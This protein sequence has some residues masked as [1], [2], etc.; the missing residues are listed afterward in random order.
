MQ[1]P[2]VTPPRRRRTALTTLFVLCAAGALAVVTALLILLISHSAPARPVLRLTEEVGDYV[3][4]FPRHGGY[5]GPTADQRDALADGVAKVL[6]GRLDS[7]RERL[8][9][10]DYTVRT[11]RL[12]GTDRTVAEVTEKHRTERG[13]GRVYVDLDHRVRW[14]VQVPHPR[15]D[16]DT[17]LI[18][19]GLF[20]R[21]PGGILVLAGAPRDAGTGISADMAH[22]RDS[23]FDAICDEL[24]ARR[25]PGIQVHGFADDSSPGHDVVLSPGPDAADPAPTRRAAKRLS[26]AGF[27][28]CR[29]WSQQCGRLEG[30]TNVQAQSAADHGVPFLHVENNRALRASAASRTRLVT[31]L[32]D[33]ARSWMKE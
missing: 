30:T 33:I 2:A 16:L 8:S 29:A 26:T 23:V 7:A 20:A 21:T 25:L 5:R 6:D 13:W 1:F 10:V 15:S 12:A 4:D 3:A 31:A 19:A 18:G 17:E 14:S 28:V 9:A 22:R 32:S 27:A 24:V 11:A